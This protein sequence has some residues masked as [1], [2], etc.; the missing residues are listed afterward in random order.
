MDGSART[1]TC[2][3]VSPWTG[4]RAVADGANAAVSEA[5]G[6]W[7][8]GSVDVMT[9]CVGVDIGSSLGVELQPV[10]RRIKTVKITLENRIDTER[11]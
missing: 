11:F 6:A 10:Y 7:V 1:L 8:A 2:V 3:E 9:R 4:G 5:R